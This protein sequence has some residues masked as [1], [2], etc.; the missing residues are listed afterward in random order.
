MKCFYTINPGEFFVADTLSDKRKDLEVFFP[1]HDHGVDLV[2]LPSKGRGRLVT[3]QVKESRP[4]SGK[5]YPPHSW[6]QVRV[7][8]I[9]A[10]DIFIFV[11]YMPKGKSTP[12][13]FAAE[14]MI[15]PQ[16]DLG[17]LCRKKKVSAGKFD[18][19]F[20]F[21]WEKGRV[22]ECREHRHPPLDV[23]RFWNAWQLIK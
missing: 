13:E 14:F 17:K 10:A 16:A 1:F 22:G 3:I 19:Y 6:H 18:F 12:Y 15:I 21:G 23:T 8:K 5:P 7:N 9:D 4:W 2:T 20:C 11:T